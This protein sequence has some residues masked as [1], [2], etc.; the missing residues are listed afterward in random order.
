MRPGDLPS[1]KVTRSQR[2][3]NSSGTFT[4]S[5]RVPGGSSSAGCD[6]IHVPAR[7]WH[8]LVL[9]EGQSMLYALINI[10][11]PELTN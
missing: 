8:P 4:S 10:N 6:I 9:A 11:E 1:A 3:I 7:V 5:S 2:A